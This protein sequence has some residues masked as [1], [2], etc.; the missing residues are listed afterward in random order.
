M[1]QVKLTC[2]F[3]DQTVLFIQLS[4]SSSFRNYLP[5]KSSLMPQIQ[6]SA[7]FVHAML[8]VQG[9]G[10]TLHLA[11]T[12]SVFGHLCIIERRFQSTGLK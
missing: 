10:S 1:D 8:F 11:I 9:A 12:V 4:S 3:A 6:I 7:V 2:L 5:L